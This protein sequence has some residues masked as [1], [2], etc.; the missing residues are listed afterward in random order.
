VLSSPFVTSESPIS[1]AVIAENI[2]RLRKHVSAKE[3]ELNSLRTELEW[4]ETGQQLFG[5][6]P[7]EPSDELPLE[8]AESQTANGAKPP[9]RNRILLIL[10]QEPRKTWKTDAVIAEMR[11]RDWLPGGEH[12][13]HHVRSMLAQMH[14][15]GQ[16][17]RMGRGQ[18]R[19][20]PERKET[21]MAE[22]AANVAAGVGVGAVAAH[23]LSGGK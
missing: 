19:L 18:Y 7:A 10:A 3:D 14:R 16:A 15:K 21:S 4:W 9:L 22:M 8:P 13:E 11:E 17:R 2:S 23:I 12:A 5:D 6:V 20:P 1:A